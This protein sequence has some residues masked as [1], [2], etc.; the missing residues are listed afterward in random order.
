MQQFDRLLLFACE[1]DW[2]HGGIKINC[3]GNAI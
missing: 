1:N 3:L 2:D